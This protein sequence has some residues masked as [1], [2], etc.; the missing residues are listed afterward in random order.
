MVIHSEHASIFLCYRNY[1][2]RLNTL[3]LNERA[4]YVLKIPFGI[5]YKYRN[6]LLLV[7]DSGV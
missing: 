5:E 2:Y 7:S 1:R 3:Q 4:L 6:S